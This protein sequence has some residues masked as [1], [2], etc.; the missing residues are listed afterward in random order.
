MV[1]SGTPRFEGMA[2]RASWSPHKHPARDQVQNIVQGSPMRPRRRQATSVRSY[3][4]HGPDDHGEGAARG[5]IH[6]R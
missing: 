5:D 6:V 4:S 2:R 1:P 3:D